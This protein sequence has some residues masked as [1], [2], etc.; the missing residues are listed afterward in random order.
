MSKYN[1]DLDLESKNSISVILNRIKPNSTILEF[2]PAHGRM[3]KY[4]RDTLNCKVY[5]VE[6][7]EKAAKHAEQFTEKIIIDSIETYSWEK[8]FAGIE[9]DYIIFA[10]VLEH[11]YHPGK[12]LERIRNFL[13]EDGS[14]LI[15]I[16]NIAHNAIILGLMKGEFN[17]G[18][19]GL[20]DDTHIRFFTKKTFDAFSN[21]SLIIN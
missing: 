4:L 10:D 20:L 21:Q 6:I 16:P 13:K 5:A 11:L 3:T 15:S 1:F 18:P 14:I 8:A 7:D 9:F 2:G 17:Y 12:V 19:V